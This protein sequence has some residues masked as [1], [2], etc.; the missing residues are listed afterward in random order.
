[1]SSASVNSIVLARSLVFKTPIEFLSYFDGDVQ[2]NS[3]GA[4]HSKF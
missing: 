4:L 3:T 1:M 2:S